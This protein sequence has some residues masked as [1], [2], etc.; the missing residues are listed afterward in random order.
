[1]AIPFK[2]FDTLVT[3]QV[4]AIQA[5][6]VQ[7]I[8][9]NIG[10]V[11]LA[12]VEANA[13]MGIW[14]EF[15]FNAVLALARAQ[16]STGSDLDSWM[17]QFNLFRLPGT[18]ASGN[19]TFS[20]STTTTQVL[21]PVGITVAVS[22][23]SVSF[24]VI[25]DPSNPNYN[26]GAQAYIMNTGVSSTLAK[27][28]CTVVG[29]IGNVAAN[30]ITTFTSPLPGINSVNNLL[31]FING[32]NT[33]SDAAFRARFVFYINSLFSANL[34]SYKYQI[35]SIPEI[36]RYNVVEN[37][38]FGGSPQPGYVY[39]VIDDSTGSP[40]LDLITRSYNAIQTIRGLAILNDVFAPA[41][42][43][44]NI[45]VDL[46][47][48]PFVTQQTITQLLTNAFVQYVNNYPFNVNIPYSKFYEIIYDVSPGNILN[49]TNL[50]VNG[51]TTDLVGG[52]NLAFI[53]GTI[54]IGYI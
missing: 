45:S 7:N 24:Q 54:T 2:S 31:P 37:T 50:L 25:P 1:M 23:L 20:R 29:T 52:N 12:M 42:T 15:I 19:V 48:S 9:F 27:V 38:T 43:S 33:E 40:P 11:E 6:S 17:A 49:A 14:I 51:G 32:K 46:T 39:V 8:D 13:G 35:A 36:T 30:T 53:I 26:S 18:Q 5:A 22:D 3:D 21:I 34:I 41:T 16:T 4:T 28:I 47:I 10:T 44:V